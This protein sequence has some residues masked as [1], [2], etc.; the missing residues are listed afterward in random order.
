MI[1]LARYALKSPFHAATVVGL[2]AVLSL[3]IPL[4]SIVSGAFVGLVILTQGLGSGA[5]VLLVSLAGITLASYLVPGL[6]PVIGVSIG[7][8]QWLPM[9]FLAEV[10]RRSQ[11]LS[12]TLVIGMLSGVAAVVIQY[13]FWPDM[14]AVW[15]E[16]V[17][18]MFQQ[19]G[20]SQGSEAEQLQAFVD[21]IVHWTVLVLVAMMYSTFVATLLLARWLQA[22]LGESQRF[23][24]EFLLLKLGK[25]VALA[26]LIAVA[27]AFIVEAN[28]LTASALVLAA[29]FLFQG[30]AV[31]HYWS[32]GS[33]LKGWLVLYYI[34]MV[35]F[36]Q[37]V[38]ATAF[39]GMIDNWAD[40]RKRM[41]PPIE[42]T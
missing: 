2:L 38:A 36:P 31:T 27:A 32:A 29:A 22:K 24:E 20:Q 40:F 13:V 4:V 17:Q 35:I 16:I 37:V 12:L 3:F 34:L 26:A 25:T 14:E 11:S 41:K 21:A 33:K 15:R 10:L 6:S 39:V 7:L 18:Q 23:R 5:R 42:K 30:L 9:V 19:G 1:S 28:W 8:V